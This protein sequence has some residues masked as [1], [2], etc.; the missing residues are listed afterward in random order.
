MPWSTWTTKSPAWKFASSCRKASAFFFFATVRIRRSPRMSCSVRTTARSVAKPFSSDST[1]RPKVPAGSAPSIPALDSRLL[2]SPCSPSRCPRRRARR[3]SR[4][5]AARAG[6]AAARCARRRRRPGTDS[7][8]D[9]RA[10]RRSSCRTGRGR[11][12][13]ALVRRAERMQRQRDPL[14]GEL[15]PRVLAEIEPADRQRAVDRRAALALRRL[16]V[17]ARLVEIL[18]SSPAAPSP[19]RR[20]GGRA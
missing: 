17:A 11:Q 18:R 7:R 16:Q 20:P 15:P 4:R 1:A 8:P 13:A 2:A 3:S 5:S 10:P 12:P 14:L 9:W 6:P 19:P